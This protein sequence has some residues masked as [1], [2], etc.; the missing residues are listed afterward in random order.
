M[1]DVDHF[2]LFNDTYGHQ[3]GDEVL[4][5]TAECIAF[6]LRTSDF[7]ARYGGEEFAILFVQV[8]EEM[9]VTLC[10]RLRRNIEAIETPYS[11]ITASFGV[12]T[13]GMAATDPEEL[14]A[15]ADQALYEAKHCGRNRVHGH[16]SLEKAA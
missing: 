2:K 7:I 10:E 13:Y 6:N 4:R 14:I 16:S 1:V 3:A 15:A 8:E 5:K 12:A 11:R 9:A